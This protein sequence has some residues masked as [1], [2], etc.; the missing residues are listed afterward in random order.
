MFQVNGVDVS[1]SSHEEAISV[2]QNAQEPIMVQVLRRSSNGKTPMAPD[3]HQ[4]SGRI[5]LP[6]DPPSDWAVAF[7][8][9]LNLSS[10]R[11]NKRY[12]L[13]R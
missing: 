3:T 10:T 12:I 2:F 11:M 9:T 5:L 4:V 1:K 6:V 7:D 13:F 8:P